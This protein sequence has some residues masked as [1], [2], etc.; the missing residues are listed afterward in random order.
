MFRTDYIL[1]MIE[2]ATAVL[3]VV[4]GLRRAQR[5]AEALAAIDRLL[6]EQWGLDLGM[7]GTLDS[8]SVVRLVATDAAVDLGKCLV[9]AELLQA[10]GEIRAELGQPAERE[11]RDLKALA[12]LLEAAQASDDT[13]L[14]TLAPRIQALTDR[15]VDTVF[16]AALNDRLGDF[17]DRLA[18]PA[19]APLEL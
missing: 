9:L 10:E 13:A 18:P 19:A 7:L 11:D 1:R 17:Y 4:L 14:P 15:L 5:P 2:Q 6:R 12:L 16:P 8:E 3:A